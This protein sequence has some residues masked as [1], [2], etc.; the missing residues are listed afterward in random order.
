MKSYSIY[1]NIGYYQ[2]SWYVLETDLETLETTDLESGGKEKMLDKA[3][4]LNSLEK[5]SEKDIDRD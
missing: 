3:K 1:Y 4:A 5:R 2:N